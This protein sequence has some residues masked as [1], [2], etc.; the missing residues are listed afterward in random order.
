MKQFRPNIL[1][2]VMALSF[3]SWAIQAE[4]IDNDA[5]ETIVVQGTL[6]STPLSEMASSIT[7]WDDASIEQRHAQHLDDMLNRAANVNFASGASRGRFI[8]IRGI[9]ERS[10]FVDPV[11]PSVGFIVDGI[12]YSGLGA[13]A[14]MFDVAQ[15]EVFKGPNS[16][17]FGADGL[18]GMINVISKEA[19]ARSSFDLQAGAANYNSWHLGAAAGGALTDSTNYRVSVH[20]N[21][22]DGFIENTFLDRD[23]T[24]NIDEFSARAKFDWQASADLNINT[25]LH[26]IDVDNGYDAF[27]LDRDRT[28]LSDE[29]GFD[30]QKSKAAAVK[31]AY[32]GLNWADLQLQLSYLQ[33]DLGYAFDE[34][35]SYVGIAPG[36][37]YSTSDEYLRDRDN[38]SAEFK[39]TSKAGVT[40]RWT[41]GAYYADKDEALQRNFFDWDAYTDAQFF[42]DVAREDAAIFGEYQYHLSERSWLTSSLRL[43][44]QKLDYQDSNQIVTSVDDTDWGAQFSYHYQTDQ[45]TM[46]YAS[47]LRSFKMGGVNGEAL[48]KVDSAGFEE[49]RDLLLAHK[50][51]K[52]ESLLGLE[53]GVKGSNAAGDLS[54]DA[55][56]FYQW[57]DDIQYKNWFVKDQSFAGFYNNAA[58]GTNYGIELQLGYQISEQVSGFANIGWLKT[59][60]NGISRQ[61][62][63]TVKVINH[64]EQAHAPEYQ[65]NAG[66]N[67]QLNSVLS[68][69]VELDAKDTFY[70]S[71]SHDSRS[72]NV[73]LLH[74]SVD[75]QMGNWKVSLYA[76]NLFDRTY[77]NRGFFF[78]NDP[79]DEYL[80]HT[81]EQFGE[82]RRVGINVN[83]HY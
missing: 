49:F 15:V 34:D 10:Q 63:T 71:Y 82:P 56:V 52:P 59:E 38:T 35:W 69:L 72:D 68:W 51:F 5:L 26:F 36:W 67:W 74:T 27:S 28:T 48:S 17:R 42:S 7:V 78:G 61:D 43:A 75:Y 50:A 83:Y 70:Y 73:V 24:Q 60:I 62:G 3:T 79:R 81:Y 16:T 64:R 22:S 54:Y 39:L 47:A 6:T 9:G 29:P 65:L 23:D 41:I 46:W 55:N 44:S 8:Q 33:A 31:A 20:Q 19:D 53:F 21:S 32:Q 13:G 2:S 18:A 25:V 77:A 30:R 12:N 76:R 58:D 1:A 4:Q 11:N 66:I 14:S 45:Q 57:R 80:E 37:E 40:N